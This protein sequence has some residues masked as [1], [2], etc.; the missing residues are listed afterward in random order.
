MYLKKSTHWKLTV[1]IALSMLAGREKVKT[2]WKFHVG[3]GTYSTASLRKEWT[4]RCPLLTT[5]NVKT[6]DQLVEIFDPDVT[7]WYIAAAWATGHL[8]KKKL[9]PANAKSIEEAQ[10]HTKV[11]V[12]RSDFV[13]SLWQNTQHVFL[14]IFFQHRDHPEQL[15]AIPKT[16]CGAISRSSVTYTARLKHQYRE[17]IDD[18]IRNF[19]RSKTVKGFMKCKT[20]KKVGP[21]Q[22]YHIDHGIH[23]NSFAN[24]MENYLKSVDDAHNSQTVIQGWQK[25]HKENSSL[26]VLCAT[27]NLQQGRFGK[28]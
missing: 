1:P 24:L 11:F 13:H 3:D 27:C 2:R 22:N 14:C 10:K 28:K 9:F 26:R 19:R 6:C 4:K 25:Y 17:A 15:N 23:E 8:L 12:G 20:C 7:N 21:G 16:L 18:Q 5:L